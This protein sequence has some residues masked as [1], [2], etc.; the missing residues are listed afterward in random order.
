MIVRCLHLRTMGF[1]GMGALCLS[2]CLFFDPG[3]SEPT[4]NAESAED[5]EVDPD[6]A[7]D[8]SE[9]PVFDPEPDEH[10]TDSADDEIATDTAPSDADDL[11]TSDAIDGGWCEEAVTVYVVDDVYLD[12]GFPDTNFDGEHLLFGDT[13]GAVQIIYLRFADATEAGLPDGAEVQSVHLCLTV[14]SPPGI[15][16]GTNIDV[17]VWQNTGCSS[18]AQEEVSWGATTCST[19]PELGALTF[20]EGDSHRC[21]ELVDS[22][23]DEAADDGFVL[24]ERIATETQITFHDREGSPLEAPVLVVEY[25]THTED[26]LECPFTVCEPHEHR[27]SSGRPQRCD[28][29]G[30]GWSDMEPCS[31]SG[32]CILGDCVPVPDGFAQYCHGDVLCQDDLECHGCFCLSRGPGDV[33]SACL[34]DLE[35]TP[36][37][38]CNGLGLCTDGA[39]DAQCAGDSDCGGQTPVCTPHRRCG[40]GDLGATCL[41]EVGCREGLVCGPDNACQAGVEGDPCEDGSL[42]CREDTPICGPE[43]TCQNGNSGDSCT[44]SADCSEHATICDDGACSTPGEETPCE[45]SGTCPFTAPFCAPDDQ[46][47]NGT[48]SDPCLND[49][50]CLIPFVCGP[51]ETCQ[52]GVEGEE[53]EGDDDCR[54][55]APICLDGLCQDG[56]AGDPCTAG[57]DCGERS[58]VC[59]PG[60]V[61]QA[62]TS[63]DPCVGPAPDHCLAETFICLDAAG[64]G[65]FCGGGPGDACSNPAECGPA[66]PI[67][68]DAGRCSSGFEGDPCDVD[69][70]CDELV[71]NCVGCYCFDG[72]EGDPCS[73]GDDCAAPLVCGLDGCHGGLDGDA[74]TDDVHCAGALVCGRG[75]CSDGEEGDPCDN[76]GDCLLSNYCGP[77]GFCRNG[78][79]GDDCYNEFECVQDDGFLCTENVCDGDICGHAL[80]DDYCLI[81]GDCVDE[82]TTPVE[83]PCMECQSDEDPVGWTPD[84]TNTCSGLPRATSE[85]SVEG[86]CVVVD[87][88]DDWD[89]CDT[90]HANG[91][92]THLL[93]DP[94]HCGTCETECTDDQ[95]CTAS[96]CDLQCPGEVDPCNDACPDYTSD[97]NNCSECDHVC[98]FNN[99]EADCVE[100][101]CVMGEC[102]GSYEDANEDPIDGCECLPTGAEVCN[103]NDDDCNGVVDDAAAEVVADDPVNCGVCGH[104]CETVDPG[105]IGVCS[106]GECGEEA[107]PGD[108]WNADGQPTNGCEYE[109]TYVGAE[110]CNELDEDCDDEIDEDFDLLT[111]VG[112]CGECDEVC[113]P[114][115]TAESACAG[116]VCFVVR[117]E[118]G[119]KDVNHIGEDGCEVEYT[120]GG[121]YWV[122]WRNEGGEIENGSFENPFGT[123][124]EAIDAAFEGYVI[125]ILQGPYS[126]GLLVDVPN[127]TLQ[128]ENRAL[129]LIVAPEFGTGIHITTDGV[130]LGSISLRGGQYGVHFEGTAGDS[131]NG[132]TVND[133]AITSIRA[134]DGLGVAAA[135][136]LLEYT[137]NQTISLTSV[138][139]VQA[140][141]GLDAIEG[142]VGGIGVGLYVLNSSVCTLTGNSIYAVTGGVGGFS[143]N[144]YGSSGN[145]GIGSGIFLADSTGC[146]INA[147]EIEAIAGGNGAGGGAY[148]TGAGG[149]GTGIYLTGSSGNNF[150]ANHMRS[151]E[152]G[153]GGPP[154]SDFHRRGADQQAF[155]FY[156][157]P[158]SRENFIL[159]GNT[160]EGETIVYVSGQDGAILADLDLTLEVNPTNFGKIVVIDSHG[161]ELR[162]NSV[163]GFIGE[164]GCSGPNRTWGCAGEVGAGI[165]LDGC[166]DC[167][168][169]GNTVSNIYGGQGGTGGYGG[170]SNGH[171]GRG[172]IAAGLFISN[173][174]GCTITNNNVLGIHGGEGGLG[175]ASSASG[176]GGVGMGVYLVE[177]TG[178]TLATNTISEIEGGRHGSAGDVRQE[179]FGIYLEEDSLENTVQLNN[180]IDDEVIIYLY[181]VDGASIEG[182]ELSV[183]T[184]PTNWGRIAVFESNDVQVVNNSIA[185]FSAEME[186]PHCSSFQCPGASGVGIRLSGCNDCIVRRNNI[187]AI[188][189]GAG[190][191][192]APDNDGAPGGNAAG[193]IVSGFGSVALESNVISSINGGSGGGTSWNGNPGAA[194]TSSCIFIEEGAFGLISLDGLTCYESGRDGTTNGH[195]VVLEANGLSPIRVVDSIIVNTTGY[196]LWNDDGN[197]S[198]A[199]WA[200]DSDLFGCAQGEVYNAVL[201]GTLSE[202]P[203]F[204]DPE[205]GDFHL[206][207]DESECSPAVDAGDT[208]SECSNEPDP[209]G[210]RVNMGAYGNTDEAATMPGVEDCPVCP[211][212]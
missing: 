4:P 152:G 125:H 172:G 48:V 157:R 62:G 32:V 9:D 153:T 150:E 45:D 54:E 112:N 61:C 94:D 22:D 167:L 164:S 206:R 154:Y 24:G 95:V 17:I 23:L 75:T 178:C 33:G 73:D 131:L 19:G 142:G 124:Q 127:L 133:V 145:G 149:M 132:G 126:G 197:T 109:C 59:G 174:N 104:I 163:S 20:P 194:G 92:E 205:A 139:N 96:G 77:S 89:H 114:P 51:S 93:T 70:D 204:V 196:C 68:T 65:G 76:N 135:G 179:A 74:C 63:G 187:S 69:E 208:T 203:L 10:A 52:A 25:R 209:N 202:D 177:T 188:V 146:S 7:N 155:G 210:C 31:E 189:G 186:N 120:P 108:L 83:Q 11:D 171:G 117:C 56:N 161:V 91:C 185:G 100:S 138:S 121:E 44:D 57:D 71:P 199:L 180:T 111:D 41:G 34:K 115:N 80:L 159:D 90:D 55:S 183:P 140:G 165:H 13:E 82:G 129:V 136:V 1:I 118:E 6:T 212:E 3:P 105:L 78:L 184:N 16:G 107:C 200:N 40:P 147:N 81:D 46:C 99:A 43:G 87:C 28:P 169:T 130:T 58:P 88:D 85:C 116:G 134:A 102:T 27:C 106:G 84:A 195:G 64:E 143:S 113:A 50:Q 144:T 119:Y 97:P 12:S 137:E 190:G 170:L 191:Q 67:C 53:C 66:A 49:D 158:D 128:G 141:T 39:A 47:H 148:T 151:I 168:V 42:Q 21:V 207:C 86:V 2:A 18:W 79:D 5:P 182:R 60:N 8:P 166:V 35:C 29:D 193:I 37:S 192:G 162:N 122:D 72:S 175:G 201:I 173:S 181:D 98:S 198:M 176:T 103:E 38:W 14:R 123:I 36:P 26:P 101:G 15:V 156:L 30:L 110:V 211:A 160:I